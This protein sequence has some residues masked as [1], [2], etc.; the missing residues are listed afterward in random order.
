MSKKICNKCGKKQIK[1]GKFWRCEVC[2]SF[3]TECGYKI[4]PDANKC[5]HCHVGFDDEVY[6]DEI[7]EEYMGEKDNNILS[8]IL[9]ILFVCYASFSI[10]SY[11]IDGSCQA[12]LLPVFICTEWDN[13]MNYDNNL[14]NKEY[15][16]CEFGEHLCESICYTACE[17][18]TFKCEGAEGICYESL[19]SSTDSFSK[20]SCSKKIELNGSIC[21]CDNDFFSIDGYCYPNKYIKN[22]YFTTDGWGHMYNPNLTMGRNYLLNYSVYFSASKY[23][24]NLDKDIY[25][26][27][28]VDPEPNYKDYILKNIDDPF[29]L[30]LIQPIVDAIKNLSDDLD[31][32]ARV[33]ISLVQW[34]PY[35]N[36]AFDEG[37]DPYELYAYEVLLNNKG[38]CG[39]KSQL[40]ILLLRELGFGTAI[41]EFPDENHATAAIKCP[42]EYSYKKTGWCFI[43]ATG[44]AYVGN[45]NNNYVDVGKLSYNPLI[46]VISDGY[47]Y[48][49]IERYIEEAKSQIGEDWFLL[50]DK[51]GAKILRK[52]GGGYTALDYG[53][54]ILEY[55]N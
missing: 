42:K 2:D 54:I 5:P 33:V 20:S 18:G 6:D 9:I 32:Q 47:E 13:S 45:S 16:V 7:I 1:I 3:C 53:D 43:E 51:N 8:T 55:P 12:I 26:Y 39:E 15:S 35:D 37:A 41:F 40:M 28:G 30:F 29:Q 36:N 27:P 52:H 44:T 46:H 21:G 49:D 11:Y 24:E 34:I 22:P 14:E 10:Y 17:E 31:F 23:F 4:N 19:P 48:K 50:E 25:Y 38:V